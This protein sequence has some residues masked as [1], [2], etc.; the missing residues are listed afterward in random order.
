MRRRICLIAG[1][2][3]LA[4]CSPPPPAPAERR[5]PEFIFMMRPGPT[6]WFVGADGKGAG[7]DYDLA[8]L[9]AREHGSTITI[10]PADHTAQI[11]EAAAKGRA[12]IGAGGLYGEAAES[13]P[14]KDP[15]IIYSAGY[16]EVEPV[17]IYNVDG[18]KPADWGDLAGET[19]GI[20]DATGLDSV[21]GPVRARHP[22]VRWNVQALPSAE[23]L[24]EQVADGTLSYAVVAS[25]ESAAARNVHLDVDVAFPAGPKQQLTWVFPAKEAKLRDEF[26]EFLRKQK[27]D[28]VLQRLLDRY[29]GY[30]RRV[31]RA[32]ASVFQE[33]MRTVLPEHRASFRQ[34]QDASSIDWRLLAAIAYQES[35][36][37]PLA[38]S[39]TNVRG[40]MMLTEETAKRLRV[41]DRLDARQSIMAGA[42][43]VAE[44]KRFLPKRIPEPD[45][46]WIALAAFNV[47]VA[48]LEDARVLAV[49]RKL[50]P[51]AWSDLKKTLPLLAQPGV[52][53]TTKYGFA[54]GG[55]AV[56][57]V[58]TVRAYYDVL[59]R[60]EK[61]YFSVAR[62][63]R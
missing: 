2:L 49:K 12:R 54:R 41:S 5:S 53:E 46:T 37:D 25:T 55:Q 22:D 14:M 60:L 17:L 18:F 27:R 39:E 33:K 26:N 36:W 47:G 10:V 6:T 45:R 35:H 29:F 19:V 28:G 30:A 15:F 44:L 58:E 38:I 50:N 51:D 56:V 7:I 31:E 59:L 34:A 62:S 1:L 13:K 4:G 20:V 11:I 23:A 42:R 32:D 48:H 52:A 43:Y 3:A 21:V 9:F 61:P 16:Y 40:M 63:E 57:F 24:I 8:Q